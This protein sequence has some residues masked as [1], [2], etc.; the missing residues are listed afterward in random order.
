MHSGLLKT[1]VIVMSL[2]L[3]P[4]PTL[5]STATAEESKTCADGTPCP[6]D[7]ELEDS[8]SDEVESL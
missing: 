2:G 7:A 8:C 1:L 4:M 3:L 6:T 5:L